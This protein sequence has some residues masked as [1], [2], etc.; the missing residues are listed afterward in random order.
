MSRNRKCISVTLDFDTYE[1]VNVLARRS[2][3]S[4]SQTINGLIWHGINNLSTARK[5]EQQEEETQ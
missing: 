5:T 1:A 2:K 3:Q 4:R